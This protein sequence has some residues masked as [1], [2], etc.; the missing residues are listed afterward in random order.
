M[1]KVN[2][3]DEMDYPLKIED[4]LLESKKYADPDSFYFMPNQD[5]EYLLNAYN[6]IKSIKPDVKD[7]LFVGGTLY[8]AII[9]GIEKKQS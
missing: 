5:L 3:P 6:T 7:I 8:S 4:A 9:K 1:P 2:V